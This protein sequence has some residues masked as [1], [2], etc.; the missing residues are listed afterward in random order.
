[1]V[2]DMNDGIAWHALLTNLN[3]CSWRNERMISIAF[4]LWHLTMA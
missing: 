4:S 3:D 2:H 1:M